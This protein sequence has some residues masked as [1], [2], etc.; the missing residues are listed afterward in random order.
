MMHMG[1]AGG[2]AAAMAACNGVVPRALDV[3]SLQR[4]LLDAGFHLGDLD[5]IR[6]LGLMR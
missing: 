5:R 2:T 6:E 1:E 4:A 3:R